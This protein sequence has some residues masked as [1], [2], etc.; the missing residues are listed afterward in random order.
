MK[1]ILLPSQEELHRFFNYKEGYLYRK[2]QTSSN[3]KIN[4]KVGYLHPSGY[5]R[6]SINCQKYSVHR[7]IWCY[8][9]GSI[10]SRLEIDHIDGNKKNN[11]IENLRLA[12]RSQNKSNNKRARCDSKSNI[13]GV[14]WHKAKSK[15]VAQIRKN[16]KNFYLGSFVNQEDAV[17]ARRAAELQYFAEFAP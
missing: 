14:Y 1:T 6:V 17:A 5:L 12:T 9:F 10:P 7:I 2:I 4:D 13:L 8:H 3:A 15:W 16:N 11:M